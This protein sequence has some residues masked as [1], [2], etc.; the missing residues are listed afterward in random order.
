MLKEWDL[1]V[2]PRRQAQDTVTCTVTATDKEGL[3]T[4]TTVS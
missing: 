4:T 1:D 3:E 2:A